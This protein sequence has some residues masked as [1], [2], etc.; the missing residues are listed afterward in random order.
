MSGGGP[1]VIRRILVPLDGSPAAEAALGHAVAIAASLEAALSVLRVV[2]A[3][4]GLDPSVGTVDWRLQRVEASAYLQEVKDRLEPEGLEVETEVVEGTT[5]DAVACLVRDRGVGLVV[6][7]THG[8]GGATGVPFGGTAHKILSSA[9]TSVMI[10]HPPAEPVS[11]PVRVGYRRVLVPTDGSSPSEWALC[12]ATRIARAQGAEL[13]VLQVVPNVELLCSRI[14]STGEEAELLE[15]LGTAQRERSERYFRELEPQLGGDGLQVRFRVVRAARVA[16]GVRQVAAEEG[17]DLIA[18][19]AHGA[20]KAVSPYGKVVQRLLSCSDLPI[21]VFQD[22]P[23][24]A[25][26]EERPPA[27]EPGR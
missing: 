20:A 2:E 27:W 24:E 16:E 5:A 7:S 3:H 17:V 26:A 18:L 10:V 21:L 14:P 9:S 19:S 13:L 8:R 22:V 1:T 25:W 23:G 4:A 15:R 6:I 11:G 12:L